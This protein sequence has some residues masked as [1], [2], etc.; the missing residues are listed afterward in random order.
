M[1]HGR[2]IEQA[3]AA[4]ERR[5]DDPEPGGSASGALA[6]SSGPLERGVAARA[7]A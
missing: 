7:H 1:K 4:D 6:S 3:E 2:E 5:F